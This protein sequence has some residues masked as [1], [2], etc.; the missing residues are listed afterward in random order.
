MKGEILFNINVFKISFLASSLEILSK[1]FKNVIESL[2]S[3]MNF[4]SFK[5][6]INFL[7]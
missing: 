7:R 2:L 1:K 6:L 3:M 4:L 5:I